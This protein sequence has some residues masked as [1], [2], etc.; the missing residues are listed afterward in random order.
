MRADL[1]VLNA[2]C[3]KIFDQDPENRSIDNP[4][5][6]FL[7]GPFLIQAFRQLYVGL[8]H[9]SGLCIDVRD[10]GHA[11]LRAGYVEELHGSGS[12]EVLQAFDR[13]WTDANPV[14]L[15]A[16]VL[17]AVTLE[18]AEWYFVLVEVVGERKAADAATDD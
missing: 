7:D 8:S 16:I 13:G 3:R 11:H 5:Q 4:C 17:R 6:A 15:S 2:F 10:T 12:E 9:F 1:I 18:D 14:A